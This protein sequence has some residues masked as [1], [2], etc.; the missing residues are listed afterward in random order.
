MQTKRHRQNVKNIV[1]IVDSVFMHENPNV[2]LAR[3]E[4][5]Q[6]RVRLVTLVHLKNRLY[7]TTSSDNAKVK[8]I[9]QD[10]KIEFCL[11][12]RKGE[13][14]GTTKP[15]CIDQNSPRSKRQSRCLQ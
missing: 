10:P 2:F 9:K 8:Q 11:L 5:D 15:E 7:A 4:G 6:P 14:K 12:F 13:R 3:S 1:L